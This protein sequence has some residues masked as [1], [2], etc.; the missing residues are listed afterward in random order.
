[1]AQVKRIRRAVDGVLVL[2][3]PRG[4]SSNQALQKVRWLLNAEKAG[5]TGSLDPLAT[6]VLPLCF[7]EATKFSQYLL[8]A[9]KGYETQARL[10]VTTTTGDAEGEVLEER[11]VTVGREALEAVLPRFRGEIEQVP[12]MYSAL[13]KDGQ[14]LYKLARAG[15]VVEREAR[16][17]T[18]ARLELLAFEAP[19]ATL[20]VSCSK[21]T[22]I[23][24]LVEDIG[25]E[26]GCGAHVAALRRTQ[27]GPFGLAQAVTLD[28]L[29]QAHAEGGNEALDRFLLPV[30]AGLEHWPLL[31]LSEHSAYYWLHGQPVRAPE[32]PK[33]GMLRVQDHE[34]R[35]I[36]IGEVTDDGRIA[37]RRLIRS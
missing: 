25:R 13:K 27:A 14:P 4:M 18:I 1:M 9:D 16:S 8:D 2:D 7:G 33:F 34:G 3:K 28:E 17:V 20:A 29:V 21:G 26:L 23:R 19:C 22:Y 11:Q 37:P 32:A 30:D 5:H 35:F 31:Q 6:G 12:P 36:G 24:T 10:G 15:E